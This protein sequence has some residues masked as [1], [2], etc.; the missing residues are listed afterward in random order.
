M[1]YHFLIAFTG[2]LSLLFAL[3]SLSASSSMQPLTRYQTIAAKL[4]SAEP[5]QIIG[6]QTRHEMVSAT[7]A[8]EINWTRKW[9]ELL[10]HS[11][12]YAFETGKRA[13]MILITENV[14]EVD[15]L[16]Q[17]SALIRHYDLPV[18]LWVMDKETEL[19]RLY[20]E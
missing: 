11:L 3:L 7:H 1:R 16:L 10:G 9:D 12:N 18:T 19:L 4:L 13:G 6:D 20:A 17:L 14:G 5:E 2:L 15:E 8:I